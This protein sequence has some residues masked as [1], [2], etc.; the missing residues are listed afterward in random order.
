[1]GS[2]KVKKRSSKAGTAPGRT[3]T[4]V[5]WVDSCVV[6]SPWPSGVREIDGHVHATGLASCKRGAPSSTRYG[7]AY[8]Q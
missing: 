7:S 1:M 8:A 6:R 3:G 2:G 5:A 4:W